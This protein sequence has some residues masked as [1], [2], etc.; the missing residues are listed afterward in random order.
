VSFEISKK[1]NIVSFAENV[2]I[3]SK[4]K[5]IKEYQED[6]L[7]IKKRGISKFYVYIEKR[8]DSNTNQ[9]NAGK[10]LMK[11]LNRM[12]TNKFAF[13]K[14]IE[15]SLINL[16]E[17]FKEQ[18]LNN[19]KD[20]NYDLSISL[21][22][23]F[24]PSYIEAGNGEIF[25]S[26]G[27]IEEDAEDFNDKNVSFDIILNKDVQPVINI[28][29]DKR[30]INTLE[31]INIALY[32]T[33]VE[34][35]DR[36]SLIVDSKEVLVNIADSDKQE[37]KRIDII[38]PEQ[39]HIILRFFFEEL[40]PTLIELSDNFVE[41]RRKYFEHDTDSYISIIKDYLQKKDENFVYI[42]SNIM[43]KLNITQ[44]LLDNS[45]YYYL[46]QADPKDKLVIIIRE[47]YYKIYN[48]G[49]K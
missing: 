47:S 28:N 49:V 23:P 40:N 16:N 1:K 18:I 37:L 27:Y 36:Y 11:I 3:L 33:G 24:L 29:E 48:A 35:E 32:G 5:E 46:Y 12:S 42:I 41:E 45:F 14:N 38:K 44:E 43:S 9:Q 25:D 6:G 4:P 20:Y 17:E 13:E 10:D 26:D 19:L 31:D 30:V 15:S 2:E 39:F 8:I 34:H 7:T 22:R 21:E